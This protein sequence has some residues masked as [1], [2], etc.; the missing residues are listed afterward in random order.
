MML[1]EQANFMGQYNLI[2]DDS[3]DK[4]IALVALHIGTPGGLE[5]WEAA[6]NLFGDEIV[7]A[8]DRQIREKPLDL[9]EVY[10]L[11]PYLRADDWSAS[12]TT[13]SQTG[14]SGEE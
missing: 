10:T 9:E 6:R 8:V 7:E 11:M 5:Y 2:D 13:E 3:R 14:L 12:Q 1:A 4:F